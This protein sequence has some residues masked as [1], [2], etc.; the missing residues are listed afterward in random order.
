MP[1]SVKLTG[2]PQTNGSAMIWHRIQPGRRYG[3]ASLELH[4]ECE[5]QE[6]VIECEEERKRESH[7]ENLE[8]LLCV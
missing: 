2:F 4:K 1:P 7:A 5:N 3:A 6:C 8:A